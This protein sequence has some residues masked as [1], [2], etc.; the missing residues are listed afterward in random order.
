MSTNST[1]VDV[2]TVKPKRRIWKYLGRGVL[3][4]IV[5][6]VAAHFAWKYSGSNQWE[7]VAERNGVVVYSM[8]TPGQTREKFRAVFQIHGKFSRLVAWMN[9]NGK[10]NKAHPMG[11]YDLRILERQGS[12]ESLTAYK[13]PLA[14]FLKPREFVIRNEFSQDPTTRVLSY[15]VT[16]VPDRIPPDD[17]CVRVPFM[18]NRWTL[19]P[20]K[21]DAVE[22]EWFIDMDLGGNVPYFLQN[23]VM[24][25]GMLNFA[26]KVQEYMDRPKYKDAKYAWLLEAGQ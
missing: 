16:G 13:Q 17:C 19:T 20:E 22:V 25:Q 6:L 7:K 9:D 18:S 11:L 2:S 14:S 26:P 5:L 1:D 15:T 24:P 8:K 23:K 12:K 21:G 3:A 10:D 4:I